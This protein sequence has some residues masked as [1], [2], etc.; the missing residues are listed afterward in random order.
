MSDFLLERF[1]DCDLGTFG[2]LT[3]DGF[4]CYSIEQP[5]RNNLVG[6]SC[7]PAGVYTC[8]RGLFPKHGNVFEVTNV[9]D[10]TAILIH[11]GNFVNDFEGCIGVG[12]A[13]GCINGTWAIKNSDAT[14]ERFM[15]YMS[16][17]NEFQLTVRW[18]EH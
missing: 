13:Y 4:T 1:C 11:Q 9:P 8:R 3:A 2:I 12:D 18:K 16:G 6:H 7:I 5:W 14:L 15:A 10:R 17:I